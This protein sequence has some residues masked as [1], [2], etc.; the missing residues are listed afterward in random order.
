MERVSIIGP[1]AAVAFVMLMIG[2][3]PSAESAARRAERRAQAEEDRLYRQQSIRRNETEAEL[4]RNLERS[5]TVPYLT[6]EGV[7]SPSP[8]ADP[9]TRKR[10]F[11]RGGF[12]GSLVGAFTFPQDWERET[13]GAELPFDEGF[14]G[15]LSLGRYFGNFR[16][17][18]ELGYRQNDLDTSL[19]D[20]DASVI[21]GML[22]LFYDWPVR[23]RLSLYGGAGAGA[24][25][26]EF[27][28]EIGVQQISFSV[29]D[30]VF[31][32]QVMAGAGYRL[33]ERTTL[34]GGYR[35][36]STSDFQ[37]NN[38]EFEP[39]VIHAAELGIRFDF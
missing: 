11:S 1:C 7:T 30:T 16:A 29:D 19:L 20:A 5:Q 10:K 9:D 3:M 34:F 27:E 32:Y 14:G 6:Q 21:S 25:N 31:A 18:A 28:G 38:A 23:D 12:Y 39:A 24:A 13:T 2:C 26:V 4:R 37:L 35:F 8:P 22:N 17:E 33:N 36:W 15:M